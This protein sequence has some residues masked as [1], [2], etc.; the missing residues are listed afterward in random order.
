MALQQPN[1]HDGAVQDAVATS[2][3]Q[4][5]GNEMIELTETRRTFSVSSSEVMPPDS[6]PVASGP[7]VLSENEAYGVLGFSLPTWKKWTILT[8]IFILQLSMNFN[9]AIYGNVAKSLMERFGI[10][11]FTSKLGQC[12]FLVLYAFGCE[13]WA[14]WS[15]ELG[16]FWVCILAVFSESYNSMMP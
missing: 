6:P 4:Q 7:H 14:P 5:A 9:A 3:P 16:R 10:T 11:L 2:S 15:E 12:V 8:S 13:A 1:N